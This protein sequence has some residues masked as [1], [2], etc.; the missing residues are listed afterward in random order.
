MHLRTLYL[1]NFRLY[2]EAAFD[3]TP[4]INTISG[5]NASGKTTV[6]EAIYLLM[7]GRSFRTAQLGDLIRQGSPYFYVEAAFLKHEVEQ[8]I[9][10]SYDGKERKIFFNSSPCRSPSDLLGLLQGALVTPDDA[11]L[12]KGAPA[13]RRQYLDMQLAQVDPLYVHHLTRYHRA[14][15]QRNC[16]LKAKNGNGIESWESEMAKAAAYVSLHRAK[17]I[18][19]LQ[20]ISR[21]LQEKLS[22]SDAALSL[23][24][25]T[26]APLQSDLA[27]Y[28]SELYRKNRR[29]EMDLGMTL[30]G[31]HKDDIAILLG[32]QEARHFGSEG[33]QRSCVAALRLA[34]WERL[35][36]QSNEL[37]LMLIDDFGISLDNERKERLMQ[38]IAQLSQVFLT[39]TEEGIQKTV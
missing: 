24:Y 4:G 39:S 8:R 1:Q 21:P 2:S 3:F 6:L 26:A 36:Q 32:E 34:E 18:Q 10:I 30:H 13:L 15:R 19:E 29:R 23:K 9:K 22:G 11:A 33:Q 31:P 38:H 37:P 5:P 35:K 20:A 14:M 25:Q 7:T 12:V 28:Y 17:A 16:L 27:F